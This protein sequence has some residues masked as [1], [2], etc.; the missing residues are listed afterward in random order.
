MAEKQLRQLVG[1]TAGLAFEVSWPADEPPEL[2]GL[3]W[4]D[5]VLW[6]AG[7]RHWAVGQDG[8]A[9]ARWTWLD[10]VEHLARAWPFLRFEETAPFGLVAAGP[11]KLRSRSLLAGVPGRS[12]SEVE[13]AVHGFQHRHD[14]A[15]GL[16][17][18][19]LPP[20]WLVRSGE[21][22]HVRAEESDS[23]LPVDA[24]LQILEEFAELVLSRV[25]SYSTP[26]GDA[27]AALWRRRAS[28]APLRAWKIRTGLPEQSYAEWAPTS[29]GAAQWWGDPLG[30]DTPLMAAARLTAA[31]PEDS[32]RAV[33]RAVAALAPC[34]TDRLDTLAEKAG[35]VLAAVVG[36]RPFEQGYALALWLRETLGN[37]G[38]PVDPQGLLESW[39]VHIGSLPDV[40]PDLDAVACWGPG[41][42][43]AVLVNETGRHA[44][45]RSGRRATLAHEIG[46]LLMDRARQLPV[47]EVLGG[48]TPFFVEQRARAFAAELLLPR[49]EAGRGVAW[50]ESFELAATRLQAEFGVSR[51]VLGWQ[52]RNGMGWRL[53]TDRERR[54]VQ[55]WCGRWREALGA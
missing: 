3:G 19:A 26:R 15:A 33:L 25:A 31:L 55:R 28:V 23:W 54:Q 17:G 50:S 1:D 44:Q 38:G 29:A 27:A 48:S 11:D 5:L 22:V 36:K 30:S 12:E 47:L 34:R 51:Q 8:R 18:V 39:G 14:L 53:L 46:H 49:D 45:A 16:K 41:H 52:I 35:P 40:A 37:H 43:P 21:C 42:G 7:R 4:G 2:A 6:V 13:Q 32:R 24:V 10:L 9:P 20:V